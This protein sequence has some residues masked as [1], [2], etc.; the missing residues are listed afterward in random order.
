MLNQTIDLHLN[1]FGVPP[2]IHMVQNDTGR[3]LRMYTLDMPIEGGET[4]ELAIHRPDDSYYTISVYVSGYDYYQADATQALTRP[5]RVECQLRVLAGGKVMST[6]TFYIMVQEAVDGLPVEQL[7]YTIYDL[8]DAAQTLEGGGLTDDIKD[9]LLDCFAHVAWVDGDGQQYYDALE[10]AL[11][12]PATLSSISAVYTQSGTVYPTT[13]LDDLEEDLVVTATY[14]DS[15]TETVTTYTLSG[16]LSVGTSTITV[17]Y[18]GKTTTFTV[19]VTAVPTLSSITAVYT[20]SGTVY[21]TDSLDSLKTDLV[22]TA[23]YSDSSTATVASTDYTLS[24]TLT[25]GTSTITVTYSGKT[26]TFTVTVTSSRAWTD[27]VAYD[28]SVYSPTID[29]YYLNQQGVVS[30]YANWKVAAF[31]NCEGASTVQ[32][33][34]SLIDARYCSFY[35]SSEV[36]ISNLNSQLASDRYYTVPS[37]AKYVRLSGTNAQIGE[38]LSGTATLVPHA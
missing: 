16:T 7:G 21:D 13:S 24:G 12:P 1:R 36:F 10:E 23:V 4:A 14:S 32:I 29:N 18:E 20:Q 6:F 33:V 19:T 28:T 26:D 11:Y 17:T 3:V 27:G 31:I 9:T 22:V 25:V 2:V 35:N 5:G 30:Y 34:N 8:I 15:S 37:G 38:F